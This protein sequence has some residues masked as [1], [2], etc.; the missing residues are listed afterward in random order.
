MLKSCRHMFGSHNLGNTGAEIY[1]A[2]H[3]MDQ[4]AR[5]VGL[6]WDSKDMEFLSK[7]KEK[8]W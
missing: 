8:G 5:D 7:P 4:I 3:M 2:V 1:G 6:Q